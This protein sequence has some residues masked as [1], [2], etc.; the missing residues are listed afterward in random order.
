M[1]TIYNRQG[2][3]IS[4]GGLWHSLEIPNV[5]HMVISLVGGGGKTSLM[6]HLADEFTQMGKKVIIT[7]TTHIG[8]PKGFPVLLIRDRLEFSKFI[9][10]YPAVMAG[11]M[12]EGRKLKG[13]TID[14]IDR[15]RPYADV[16]LVESDGARQLPFKVPENHEPVLYPQSAVVIGCAGLD[17]LSQKMADQCFR[18]S[19]ACRL[20]G[21][22]PDDLITAADVATVLTSTAGSKKDVGTIPFRVVLNKA[23]TPRR[24][25]Q[26][27]EVLNLIQQEI[28]IMTSFRREYEPLS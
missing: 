25:E 1:I 16:V 22:N 6:Y 28:G 15:I 2:A 8:L 11:E 3:D 19:T 5:P 20:L 24:L 4:D 23:D 18:L 7:T 10:E 9:W 17:C 27:S 12:I 21:K 13:I 26:G 14:Q